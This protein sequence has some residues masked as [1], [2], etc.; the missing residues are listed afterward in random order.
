MSLLKNDAS[1]ESGS[2]TA[3][4]RSSSLRLRRRQLLALGG[5]ALLASA[6]GGALFSRELNSTGER[7]VS[8]SGAVT[9][10]HALAWMQANGTSTSAVAI[11]FRG[12][13]AL[14]H[15]TRDNS[16]LIISRRPGTVALEI[17]LERGD[18]V[19]RFASSPGHHFSGHA[20]TSADGRYVFSTEGDNVSG[21]G[22][23]VVRDANDYTQL[24]VFPSNGIGP[25][26]LRMM[27][28]SDLLVVANGGI[29]TRPESGRKAL[30]LDTM[31]SNLSY[32]DVSSGRV[33]AQYQPADS[34]S[35]IRHLDVTSD[36]VLV[37]AVQFQRDAAAHNRIVA[38]AG[39]QH[40]GQAL[41]PFKQPEVVL[42]RF[43]DYVGSV[44]VCNR[45]RV[46]GFTSPRG[47]LAAFWHVDSGE[48]VGY[49]SMRDVCGIAV[50]QEQGAFVL[51]NSFGEIRLL[52]TAAITERRDQ[53]FRLAER[54]WD[55]HLLVTRAG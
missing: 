30:N 19:S 47:N 42:D 1:L 43:Q 4:V 45:S 32:L 39:V 13:A 9:D 55:N 26:D 5:T 50:S 14:A 38:L 11:P 40:P 22:R 31:Q 20:C 36:G 16:V 27:P 46:A 18:L 37:Y 7:W 2:E 3:A 21:Q 25:H 35:S 34:K 44:A 54:R 53:R 8:A 51:S 6:G 41:Q 29:L 33:L 28:N 10:N 23:I 24:E 15:P 17:D 52:D 48:C 12:H 49:H